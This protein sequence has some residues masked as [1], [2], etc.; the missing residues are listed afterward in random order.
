MYDL[1]LYYDN[2]AMFCN[3]YFGD[4]L[5]TGTFD[6][7]LSIMRFSVFSLVNIV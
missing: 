3:L 1:L 5:M 6:D 4:S 7:N 2:V